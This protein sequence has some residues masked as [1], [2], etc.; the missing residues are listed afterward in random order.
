MDAQ[1]EAAFVKT[2]EEQ[3]RD[4]TLILITH[5]H[6]LLTLVDHLILMDQGHVIMSG[7]RDEV[8]EAIASGNI[9]VPKG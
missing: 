5:R 3:S 7:P 9:K 8:M 1:A 2:I 4:K 6:H